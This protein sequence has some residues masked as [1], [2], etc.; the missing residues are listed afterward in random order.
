MHFKM[1]GL[2]EQVLQDFDN[3]FFIPKGTSKVLRFYIFHYS[4]VFKYLE[5]SLNLLDAN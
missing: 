3:N 1:E 5:Q 4:F 2:N